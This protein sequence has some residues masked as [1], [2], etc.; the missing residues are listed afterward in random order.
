MM[1]SKPKSRLAGSYSALAA[2]VLVVAGGVA[3]A[4]SFDDFFTRIIRDDPKGIAA[5]VQRGF[6]PNTLNDKGET[7]L[8][9]AFKLDSYRA[10]KGLIDL[11]S[12]NVNL[13][14]A[15]G[16]TPLMMAAIK[17]QIDL[18]K[19]L[20]ARDADVNREGWT[21]LHYAVS[22]PS[23]DGSDLKMVALLL[24]EHAFI[25]AASPNGTTP[26]MM[27]AQYGTRSAVQLLIKEGADPK[28][29]NQQGQTAVDFATR[30]DRS[31]VVDWLKQAGGAAGGGAPGVAAAKGNAAAG[32]TPP[33]AAPAAPGVYVPQAPA[34]PQEGRKKIQSN[35]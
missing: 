10:A 20:I 7:G 26:L 27:A 23:E 9:Q 19:A 31:E 5:L 34:F 25:D 18:A 8:T 12:T 3:Q 11:P 24:E 29:K 17:G 13:P 21:P 14:N 33:A 30:A 4:G 1:K 16:E 22:A 28:L 35:W 6:D 15:K 2:I 32:K